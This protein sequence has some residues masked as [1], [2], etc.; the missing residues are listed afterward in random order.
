MGHVRLFGARAKRI[1][2]RVL[3]RHPATV[4]GRW[5]LNCPKFVLYLKRVLAYHIDNVSTFTWEQT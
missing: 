2:G 5:R 1:F 3:G 4:G